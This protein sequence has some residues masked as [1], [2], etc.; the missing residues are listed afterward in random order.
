MATALLRRQLLQSGSH[1]R[2]FSSSPIAAAGAVK[3]LG[4]IGAGQMVS[5]LQGQLALSITDFHDR[6]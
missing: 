4:V 3:R 1:A 5:T 6:A 2:T